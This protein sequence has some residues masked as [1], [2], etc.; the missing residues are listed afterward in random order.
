MDPETPDI[1][2]YST[3]YQRVR[4]LL[5]GFDYRPSLEEVTEWL[6]SDDPHLISMGLQAGHQHL[7]QSLLDEFSSFNSRI[8]DAE[9]EFIKLLERNVAGLIEKKRD[10]SETLSGNELERL[11]FDAAKL[12]SDQLMALDRA[13]PPQVIKRHLMES[14]SQVQQPYQ[15]L[16]MVEARELKQ[17]LRAAVSRAVL[18]ISGRA[19][20]DNRRRV[21]ALEGER[22]LQQ[23]DGGS[24][25]APKTPADVSLREEFFD[26]IRSD[27]EARYGSTILRDIISLP[28]ARSTSHIQQF[29]SLNSP[30]TEIFT[31][32]KEERD[33][34]SLIANTNWRKSKSGGYG[35]R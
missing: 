31:H 1:T 29:R 2:G 18:T 26:S 19:R 21:V 33:V 23:L 13:W 35:L 24:G 11:W 12:A 17:E 16:A 10:A 3:E 32:S 27:L 8:N 5:A 6:G 22:I 14:A 9:N 15:G 7:L 30:I 20:D 4:A 34:K 28:G 25:V